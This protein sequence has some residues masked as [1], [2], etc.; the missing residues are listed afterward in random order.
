MG[1]SGE[2]LRP[3]SPVAVPPAGESMTRRVTLLPAT[4]PVA[5]VAAQIS[6]TDAAPGGRSEEAR[7]LSARILS[8]A[9]SAR[10]VPDLFRLYELREDVEDLG[11]IASAFDA[12]AAST[13]A[14]PE[15]RATALEL[16][17]QIATAQ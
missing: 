1:P 13:H 16:R 9:D 6:P 8:E 5:A 11:V 14:L 3:G 15:A 4:L 17:A 10:A 7:T 12:V 2:P